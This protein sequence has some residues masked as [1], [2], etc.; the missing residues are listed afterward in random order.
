MSGCKA[1]RTGVSR[2]IC[3]I[4]WPGNRR[5]LDRSIGVG[6][7]RRFLTCIR[8]S[9]VRGLCGFAGRRCGGSYG[10][11]FISGRI[12]F[13]CIV[14]L[15]LLDS[16]W[17]GLISSPPLFLVILCSLISVFLYRK[18]Y[19]NNK[20]N[21]LMVDS[22][23]FIHLRAVENQRSSDINIIRITISFKSYL[24]VFPSSFVQNGG[25]SVKIK[26]KW[27]SS[28]LHIWTTILD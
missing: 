22:R 1:N 20:N 3:F 5:I 17:N 11:G 27:L 13:T 6:G 19:L 8:R 4:L 26:I 24:L 15:S 9:S 16:F 14:S 2:V 23:S 25:Q 10:S 12:T 21:T 28:H 18:R 7:G